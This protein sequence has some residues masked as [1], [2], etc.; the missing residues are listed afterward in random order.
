MKSKYFIS[1]LVL[2]QLIVHSQSSDDHEFDYWKHYED[3]VHHDDET[4]EGVQ[5][6]DDAE[7]CYSDYECCSGVC[8]HHWPPTT[9][10]VFGTCGPVPDCQVKQLKNKQHISA[11]KARLQT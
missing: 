5:C 4:A 9:T 10:P 2:A 7:Y 6:L 3:T 1:F 8:S 11:R